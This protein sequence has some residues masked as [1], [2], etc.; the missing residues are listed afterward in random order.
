MTD[1]ET[2]DVILEMRVLKQRFEDFSEK[3]DEYRKLL[4][5]KLNKV[6]DKIAELP[7]RERKI[8]YAGIVRQLG[9]L[10]GLLSV[11]VVAI[12]LEWIKK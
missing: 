7:C 5:D 3:T 10:W 9:L 8:F 1:Q 12:I 6:I 4:C 2:F 11:L